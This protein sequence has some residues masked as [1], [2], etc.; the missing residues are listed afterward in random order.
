[1]YNQDFNDEADDEDEGYFNDPDDK[2]SFGGHQA[3]GSK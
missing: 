1:M 2:I 3:I